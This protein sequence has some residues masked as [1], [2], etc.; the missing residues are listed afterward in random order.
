MSLFVDQS[1]DALRAAW[2]T[3]WQRATQGQPL[4]PLQAQMA[5]LI[6]AHP[7]YHPQLAAGASETEGDFYLHL[8]LHM[9]LREQ[10]GTDRPVGIRALHQRLTRRGTAHEAEHRLMEV[11]GEMLWQAQRTG[12]PPDERSYWEALQRL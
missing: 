3:A 12:H 6:D 9:A 2:R 10:L 11:L 7:E 5:A 1:R 8:G 4:E